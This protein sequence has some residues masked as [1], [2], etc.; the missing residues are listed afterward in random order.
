MFG[1][2]GRGEM[3]RKRSQKGVHSLG[4]LGVFACARLRFATEQKWSGSQHLTLCEESYAC[5]SPHGPGS[6][7][8][9]DIFEDD[10]RLRFLRPWPKL[11]RRRAANLVAGRSAWWF[12]YTVRFNRPFHF[13]FYAKGLFGPT[14]R[15]SIARG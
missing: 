11:A 3:F 5:D 15:T 7:R 12:T 1:E 8:R 2:R 6:D 13:F 14:G 10:D 4:V 9:E